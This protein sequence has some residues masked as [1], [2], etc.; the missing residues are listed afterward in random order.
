MT[1]SPD[2]RRAPRFVLGHRLALAREVANMD[3]VAM[4]EILDVTP[5]SISNYENS[6]TTPSKLQL[7]AWAVATGVDVEWLKTGVAQGEGPRDG[8]NGPLS[9]YSADHLA[10]I[11]P[12][13]REGW[14]FGPSAA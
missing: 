9:D 6:R 13:F 2:E 14:T 5:Q 1:I 4:A 11:V 8:V 12:L 3:R 7:N 10:P